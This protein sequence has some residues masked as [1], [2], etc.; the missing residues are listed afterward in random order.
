[1]HEITCQLRQIPVNTI[2]YQKVDRLTSHFDVEAGREG[3]RRTFRGA[4]AFDLFDTDGNG[5]IDAKEL[6][7]AM[8]ALGFEPMKEEIH[9][10]I[11]NADTE[12]TGAISFAQFLT[13]M[14]KKM[15]ERNPEDEIQ[16]A[17]RLFDDDNT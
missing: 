11:T 16:K 6:K 14:T 10:M 5:S 3:P 15:E 8:K 7:V 1:M 4:A 13:M 17:F 12:A 2:R 9:R